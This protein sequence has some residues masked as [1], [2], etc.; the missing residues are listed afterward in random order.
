MQRIAVR[1]KRAYLDIKFL[2]CVNKGIELCLV[3][4]QLGRVAVSLSGISTRAHL[5]GMYAKTRDYRKRFL[6]SF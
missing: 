5:N 4:K 6:K 2:E 3:G 1:G